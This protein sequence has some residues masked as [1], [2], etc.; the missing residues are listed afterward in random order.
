MNRKSNSSRLVR[1]YRW[2]YIFHVIDMSDW[3]SDIAI[4]PEADLV[5]QFLDVTTSSIPRHPSSQL[6]FF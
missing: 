4:Q 6:T 1:H 2:H 3:S 5:S